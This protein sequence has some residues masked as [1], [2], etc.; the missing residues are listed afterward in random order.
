MQEI[1]IRHGLN[2]PGVTYQCDQ[3]FLANR[4]GSCSDAQWTAIEALKASAPVLAELRRVLA[5]A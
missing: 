1:G 2:S 3:G 4:R 5:C